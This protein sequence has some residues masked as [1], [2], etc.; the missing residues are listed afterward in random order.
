MDRMELITERLWIRQENKKLQ[1][2]A[3]KHWLVN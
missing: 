2:Y 1:R 3:W